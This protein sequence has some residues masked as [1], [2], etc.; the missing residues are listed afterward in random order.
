MAPACPRARIT[1]I[2]GVAAAALAFVLAP[3]AASAAGAES[4][5][6]ASRTG[7]ADAES[8]EFVGAVGGRI[9]TVGIS[10]RICAT[11]RH[12]RVECW[13]PGGLE[14]QVPAPRGRFVA[15]DG[16]AYNGSG[17]GIRPSGRATCWHTEGWPFAPRGK[18]T[19][20]EVGDYDECGLRASGRISC[21]EQM[22]DLPTG[23]FENFSLDGMS[24]CGIHLSGTLACATH[25]DYLKDPPE[26]TFTTVS[27]DDSYAC[28]LRTNGKLACW[29]HTYW[30]DQIV[31]KGDFVD[32]VVGSRGAC[33]LR[34]T[35][36]LACWGGFGGDATPAG[37]Y[38]FVV[39]DG[40]DDRACGQRADDRLVCWRAG[41]EELRPTFEEDFVSAW[42]GEQVAWE[43]VLPELTSPVTNWHVY[44][45]ALPEG[46][47][48]DPA[49]GALTGA[50]TETGWF[51]VE[52]EADHRLLPD[53]RGKL[54]I[55]ID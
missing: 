43:P 50:A 14:L 40:R 36:E 5:V 46:L 6:A 35:G 29:G 19:E 53:L 23:R 39:L 44:S 26:G 55:K 45:G 52:L 33:A 13:G 8:G 18:H 31:P 22:S 11:D 32:V 2:T 27:V 30:S 16:V 37:R 38:Q 7:A 20:I 51:D 17:C 25:D 10:D 15:L 47:V 54:T 49:T 42:A 12:D 21:W 3:A 41:G 24:A 48:L 4:P 28:A 1:K 9:G 34:T